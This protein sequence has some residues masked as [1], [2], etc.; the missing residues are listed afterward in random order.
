M[1]EMCDLK[2]VVIFIQ[3]VL[4]FVLSRKIIKFF[5]FHKKFLAKT[6]SELILRQHMFLIKNVWAEWRCWEQ[7]LIS[8]I[9]YKDLSQTEDSVFEISQELS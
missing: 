7:N 6:F 1:I 4:S 9:K 8:F 2:N 5:C 3:T